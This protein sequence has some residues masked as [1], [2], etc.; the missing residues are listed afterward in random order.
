MPVSSSPSFKRGRE[1]RVSCSYSEGFGFT[2]ISQ[3]AI[4]QHEISKYFTSASERILN[5]CIDRRYQIHSNSKS[6]N[7]GEI[8]SVTGH[9]GSSLLLWLFSKL[10]L[11][12]TLQ[13]AC[14]NVLRALFPMLAQVTQ[15]GNLD[16]HTE[17][18]VQWKTHKLSPISQQKMSK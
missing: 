1:T 8:S 6:S 11:R 13:A 7:N 14:L 5:I 15:N 16:P 9:P 18:Y 10:W 2:I 3:S 17:N 12:T 4:L